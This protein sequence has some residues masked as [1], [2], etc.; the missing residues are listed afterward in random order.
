MQPKIDGKYYF[1]QILLVEVLVLEGTRIS[2]LLL[3]LHQE[4]KP[5]KAVL[6]HD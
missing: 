2:F 5:A 1:N 4:D 6:C 3:S